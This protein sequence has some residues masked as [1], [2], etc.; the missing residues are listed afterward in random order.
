MANPTALAIRGGDASELVGIDLAE[1][2]QRWG[3]R[4]ADGTPCPLDE[5]PLA[6]AIMHGETTVNE[7]LIVVGE[8]GKQHWLLANAAP[9]R[10]SDGSIT[11]GVVVF[12]DVTDS[13][14]AAEKIRELN[15]ELENRVHERTMQLEESNRELESF[16]YSVSH[17]LRAPVR[18]L[19]GFSQILLEDYGDQLDE[20]GRDYLHRIGHS[21]QRMGD[22]I[23]DLLALSRFS[24]TEMNRVKVD[25]S[26]IAGEIAIDLK[27]SGVDR[28]VEFIITPGLTAKA[29]NGLI[30]VVLDNLMRNAWKFTSKTENAVIEFGS[31]KDGRNKVF[32]VKDN[33]AGFDMA[34]V[35]KLFGVFQRLH[36]SSEFGGTGIG[37]ATVNR[38]V[39]RHG[40]RV[41]AEG[42]V[43]EGATFFFT[44]P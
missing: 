36:T 15:A 14:V 30:R 34:Y 13:R 33:G 35:D 5:L 41:W 31:K 24:R 18:H 19:D 7:E 8:D 29:D 38:I 23:D 1:N 44:L 43:G 32:F 20:K 42:K 2:V 3:T 9:I 16:A 17:D 21:A 25:L 28:K 22:L 11:A 40:G 12:Q 39:R 27:E 26:T 6:R 10:D 4:K 37:L